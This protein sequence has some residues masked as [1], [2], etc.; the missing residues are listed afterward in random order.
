MYEKIDEAMVIWLRQMREKSAIIS[1]PL[2]KEQASKFA[3]LLNIPNFEPSNGWIS[4]WKGRNSI[5]YK[6][7]QGEKAAANNTSASFWVKTILPGLIQD[8]APNEVYNADETGLFFKA[9]P[10]GSLVFKE[11]KPSGVKFPKDRITLL[12]ICNMDGSDKKVFS[13]GRAKKPHSF[14]GKQIPIKYFANQKSWMTSTIWTNILLEFDKEL[15]KQNK[16]II[17]FV[18]NAACHQ[19]NDECTLKNINVK[20]LPANTTSLIQPLDQGIIHCFKVFYRQ[21]LMRRQ[22]L[23]LENGEKL[24]DFS[25]KFTILDALKIVK[26]SWWL[27]TPNT[28]ENCFKKAGFYPSNLDFEPIEHEI[29]LPSEE[30]ENFEQYVNCDSNLECYGELTAEEI[31]EEIIEENVAEE[32]EEILCQSL[33]PSKTEAIKALHILRQYFE[34]KGENTNAIDKVEEELFAL[35]AENLIQK[36]ISDYMKSL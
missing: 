28:I 8:Y 20:Y 21:N 19:L 11:E 18:D 10:S 3:Q 1:G 31:I 35:A 7:I 16:K 9:L 22:L 12:F 2:I 6:T 29:Q 26:R 4:R 23:T 30:V 17:L 24:Q 33:P 27:V 13:I 25:K 15:S 36:K 5:K 14:R 34:V 32:E